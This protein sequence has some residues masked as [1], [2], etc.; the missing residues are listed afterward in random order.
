MDEFELIEHAFRR[1]APFVHR[2]TRLGNGDDASIHAVPEGLELTVSTDISVQ[3]VHWPQDFP[4]PDA[5]CRAVN[6]SLSDMAAMGATP[7]WIWLGVMAKTSD[8]AD[9][10]GEGAARVL[11]SVGVEL[12]GGDTV[13]AAVNALAVT[14]GGLLPRGHG[15]R[16]DAARTGEDVWLC[17]SVGLASRGL[18]QWQ[19]GERTGSCI[20]AF[21]DVCPLLNEGVRL[22]E[23]GVACCI[24]VSDGLLAD[25]RHVSGASGIALHLHLADVPGFDELKAE[26][27][28]EEAMRYVLGGGEDYALLF[29]AAPSARESLRDI[30]RRIGDCR[31]GRGVHVNLHGREVYCDRSGYNHFG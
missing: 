25:A 31:Q 22:R 10:I 19:A 1:R 23:M 30:A 7:A 5:A 28:E 16:R 21:R 24:D 11:K 3:G 12:A 13:H 27:D 29:T 2:L 14:V 20:A 17:G 9:R 8:Q 26:M 15:M 4:L 18:R 6:A